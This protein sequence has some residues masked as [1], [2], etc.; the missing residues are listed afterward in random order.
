M[1]QPQS[2]IPITI[3]FALY[4]YVYMHSNS[5]ETAGAT[6]VKLGEAVDLEVRINLQ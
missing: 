6:E 2:K 4:V 5:S 3:R 1:S